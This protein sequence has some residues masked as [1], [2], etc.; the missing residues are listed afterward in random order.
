MRVYFF[1]LDLERS[2]AACR[3][4]G[5][6]T[7]PPPSGEPPDLAI[8]GFLTAEL[9][10]KKANGPVTPCDR[11]FL[12]GDPA[13]KRQVASKKRVR[14][15]GLQ[16]PAS[17]LQSRFDGPVGDEPLFVETPVLSKACDAPLGRKPSERGHLYQEFI[18]DRGQRGRSVEPLVQCGFALWC[19]GVYL[20][21][22]PTALE[23]V[24]LLN[25]PGPLKSAEFAVYLLELRLPKVPHRSGKNII[26]PKT[27]S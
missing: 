16:D 18:T 27:I 10:L 5:G 21:R 13:L 8:T 4:R 11:I 23:D 14:H 15:G 9:P 7:P 2:A 22:R 24:S 26:P 1:R 20:L 17:L 25:K 19:D 3:S 12:V 6:L